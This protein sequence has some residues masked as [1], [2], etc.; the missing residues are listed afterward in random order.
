[1]NLEM[2]CLSFRGLLTLASDFQAEE[3]IALNPPGLRKGMMFC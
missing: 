3:C 2:G 1:M